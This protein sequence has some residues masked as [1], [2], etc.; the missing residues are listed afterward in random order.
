MIPNRFSV[1][2]GRTL[3]AALSIFA[4][5]VLISSSMSAAEPAAAANVRNLNNATLRLLDQSRKSSATEK[6]LLKTQAAALLKKRAAALQALIKSDPKRALT[7]SFSPELLA[8]L[9][10]SLSADAAT[11]ESHVRTRGKVEHWIYEMVDKTSR[12]E[13]RMTIQGQ[14]VR[15]HFAGQSPTVDSSDILELSGVAIGTE[16]AVSTATVVRSTSAISSDENV[17]LAGFSS[18][19]SSWRTTTLFIL[20]F[21][22]LALVSNTRKRLV[23]SLKHFSV[24]LLVFAIVLSSSVQSFGQSSSCSTFGSQKVAVLLVTFPGATPPSFITPQGVHDMFFSTTGPSLDGYWREASYGQTWAEG[25]VFGWYT[26]DNTYANCGRMDLLRDAAIAAASNAGVDIQNYSRIYVVTT[27]FGCGW[28]G[29]SLGAC[30]TLSSPVG[31]FVASVSFLNASWQ[32]SQQQGAL[33]AAHEGGH[34]MGLGHAQL[35]RF[36]TE[37]LGSINSS[38]TLAEY[39]DAFSDMAS[40]NFGHYAIP[41]KADFLGWM[42]PQDVQLVQSS[43]TYTIAP[44]ELSSSSSRGLKVQRGTANTGYY[45]WIEYRQPIGNYDSTLMPAAPVGALIHYQDPTTGGRTQLLDF[46]P[47]TSAITDAALVPGS[48]WD[49]PYSDLSISVVS[50]TSTALTVNV[51]YGGT[52]TCTRSNPTLTVSPLN[53][54]IYPGDTAAYGLTLRNNDSAG[55]LQTTFAFSSSKPSG[56]TT[57][58][59]SNSVTLGPGQSASVTMTKTGPSSTLPG[60]YA[61]DAVAAS[62]TYS[63]SGDANVTVMAASAPSLSATLSVSSSSFTRKN[64]I[65]ITVSATSGSN[66]A[67]GV[68]VTFSVK[69][70]D[71]KVVTQTAM[72]SSSG[73]STWNYRPGPKSSV[74]TYSATAQVTFAPSGSNPQ[75]VTTNTVTFVVK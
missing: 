28:T 67:S 39:G 75:T 46:N 15:L 60:T 32:G 56:W 12:S 18:T 52:V 62:S 43:G 1:S 25:D 35:R 36:G 3:G 10:S 41:H 2:Q 72:T 69:K 30:T 29:M 70:P 68:S 49:D 4:I 5:T 71:G 19:E 53:P 26:L 9:Q 66:A 37:A 14:A 40:S 51:N 54:S 44:L 45:L 65:P 74:G 50:A 23:S 61:V 33:N 13:L 11:L 58:F 48:S 24:Y 64:T 22:A 34:N 31:S 42:G 73:S 55:C 21:L 8:D 59:T 7:F 63:D 27:D 17:V 38:G 20:G 16:M 57:A 6:A 47:A